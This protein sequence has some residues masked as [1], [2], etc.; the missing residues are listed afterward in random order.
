MGAAALVLVQAPSGAVQATG[1]D[2]PAW[3]NGWSWTYQTTFHYNDSS[4][5][6]DATINENVTYAVAGSTT[7][8][9]QDAYLLNISGNITG[10]SGGTDVSGVGHVTLSSFSGSVSGTRI[11]RK[12]DLALLQENQQ[13]VAHTTA[14]CCVVVSAG[15]DANINLTLTPD[16]GW[17]THDF[18]LNNGD[19]WH[20]SENVHYTG[21]FSYTSSLANGSSPFDGSFPFDATST[22]TN[23]NV[24]LP[25]GTV[26]TNAISAQA[27]T[28][29]GTVID[30]IWWAPSY[31]NDAKEH[32]QLPLDSATLTIDRNLS[33]ANTPAPGTSLTATITPSLTCAGGT[34]TVDGKLGNTAGTPVTITLDKSPVTAGQ[35]VTVNTT[36]GANGNY[37]ASLPVPSENDGANKNGSR[38][39]WGVYVT[40]GGTATAATL[41]VTPKDCT[42]LQYTGMTSAPRGTNATVSA[43]LTDLGGGSAAGRVVTFSLTG[44]GSVNGTTNASGLATAT[45][46]VGSS[47]RSATISASFA[48][49]STMEAA[50]DSAAF[51]VQKVGTTTTVSPSSPSVDAGDSVT[52]TADVSSVVGGAGTPDGTV[53]FLVDGANFGGATPLS[54]GEATSAAITFPADEVGD[55]TVQAVYSG[56]GDFFGST[57]PEVTFAVTPTRSPST[58]TA[59]VTP[60]TSVFGQDVTLGADVVGS[61]ATP[62]GTVTFKRGGTVIASAPLDGSGHATASTAS[63]PV[64]TH[65]IVAVYSGDSTYK[66]STSAPQTE[67]VSKADVTVEVQTSGSPTVTGEAVDVTATIGAAAPGSGTPGGTAQLQVDGSDVGSPVAVVGGTAAFDPV[68]SLHVGNHTVK[69]VYNGD[70]SFRTGNGATTQVVDQAGTTTTVVA[71]P[72]VSNE[73]AP[74]TA[75]A[76][77]VANTPG[78][79]TPTGNVSFTADGDPIGAVA[80]DGDGRAEITIDNLAPGDH[81]IRATYAGTADYAASTSDP[82]NH[83]VI[84]GAAV[85]PTTL[86]LSSSENPTS[87][88]RL[89]SFTANVAADDG[90]TPTGAVQFSVD[91]TNL[92]EPVPVG[93]DGIATSAQLAAPAPGAHTVIASFQADAGYAGSGSVITQTVT[94]AAVHVTVSSSDD[95]S[96][97]GQGV[98]FTAHVASAQEGTAAPT[99]VVQFSVD[100]VELGDAVALPSDGTAVSPSISDLAPG[101]HVVTALYSGDGNFVSDQ[102]TLTQAVA[103]IGTTT[104]LT[105]SAASITYGDSVDLTATV[106]P[107]STALGAPNGTV[108]FRD[109]STSLGTVPVMPSGSTGSAHLTVSGLG[110]GAHAITAVYSGATAFAGSSSATKTVDV[111]KAATTLDAQAAVVKLIPLGLPIGLLQVTLRDGHGQPVAG[112]PVVFTVGNK[113]ACTATTGSDGV[114]SC[115]ARPLL[116]DLVLNNG[117]TATFAGDADHLPSSDRG[118]ILK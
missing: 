70:A 73:G 69:V 25:V 41:V 94:D 27:N 52:F 92:G 57:S 53:Q 67:V 86:Q 68:T 35:K 107:A 55:H 105:L 106:T 45:L 82:V 46:P 30:N 93:A 111:A 81:V 76:T 90:S 59:S 80:L 63:L 74:F 60:D 89:I 14:K 88:G 10:G 99:G 65:S 5:N 83:S 15:V 97:Y 77:V 20:N 95:H 13:Q 54:G 112:E 75:T 38:A 23:Q 8:D 58:T 12:S 1:N 118:P 34:T 64:G 2:V 3:S 32:M 114:A 37:S 72:S 91:G 11:V 50:D 62:T 47:V 71:N 84:E 103:K 28:S 18:P 21:G 44:A 113:T 42:T 31:K 39:N 48:G 100:G 104:A 22:V 49:N 98:H 102:A 78:S 116:L 117:Y 96:D 43:K 101:D 110:G 51:D 36:T 56:S 109:G 115:N 108:E 66:S 61:G 85:V 33:S 19:S 24:S 40:G 6:T 26:A 17:R 4:S 29:S 9:G 79:G 87:Y 7:F 16:P